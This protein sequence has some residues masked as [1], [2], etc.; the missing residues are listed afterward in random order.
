MRDLQ[1]TFVHCT[2]LQCTS[3]L[4]FSIYLRSSDGWEV[5]LTNFVIPSKANGDS[6][7]DKWMYCVSLVFRRGSLT[8]AHSNEQNGIDLCVRE[9]QKDESVGEVS[10]S[11]FQSP[12]FTTSSDD[13]RS[14]SRTMKVSQELREFKSKLQE[15]NWSQQVGQGATIGLALISRRNVTHA[16]RE[17]LS[18][19]YNDFCAV[20]SCDEGRDEKKARNI[21]FCQPLVDILGVFTHSQGV[22]PTALSCL[23]QPY[24]AYNTS[25]W[26][27][28]PL[29]DQS[30]LLM[31]TSGMQLMQ[32]LPPVP[33]ALAF[34]T[35]LLEQKVC[36][37]GAWYYDF[38]TSNISHNI[39][40]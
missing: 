37:T 4:I 6:V 11:D 29:S 16:M 3:S 30:E 15:Q 31:K 32:A 10:G 18:L 25:R 38:L 33:L 20:K 17:T 23:L 35:L 5:S 2:A 9:L 34:I 40:F 7:D 19:L 13:G 22:E 39:V 36:V 8:R 1:S 24:H 27:H 21:F 26:V 28:R 12:L 14:V